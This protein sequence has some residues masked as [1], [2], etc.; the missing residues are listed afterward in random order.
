MN[1]VKFYSHRH[2]IDTTIKS[3]GIAIAISLQNL[4]ES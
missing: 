4:L 1:V 3:V 2:D